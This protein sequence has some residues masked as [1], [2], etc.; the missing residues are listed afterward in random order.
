[1]R[2][3]V[4]GSSGGIGAALVTALSARGDQVIGVSR[5]SDGLDVTDEASVSRVLGGLDGVFDLVM[6]ATGALEIGPHRP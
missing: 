1:M 3:L 5:S 2:A 4:I 6:V